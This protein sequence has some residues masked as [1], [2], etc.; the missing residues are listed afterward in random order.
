MVSILLSLFLN[1]KCMAESL[2]AYG[3]DGKIVKT[4]E[5]K[6]LLAE[7]RKSSEETGDA[8]LSVDCIHVMLSDA[9]GKLYIVQRA[10][11]PENPFL[12]D[13]TAGGHVSVGE[14]HD[15][16]VL[17]ELK[18]ELDIDAVLVSSE[19]E[20]AELL[21]TIDLTRQAVIKKI[22]A[23][24]WHKSVRKVKDGAWVKRDNPHVYLGVYEGEVRYADG[25]AQDLIKQ[26]RDE[27]KTALAAN[28][29]GFTY[30]LGEIIDMYYDQLK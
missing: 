13:K 7:I 17:R 22:D 3:P 29:E 18:E 19:A 12:F 15:E 10:D 16:T 9:R 4:Q 8:P 21:K 11:K 5:R 20:Y 25:E 23:K 2:N 27:L 26:N 28:P 6:P 14:S 30:D 24:F 1:F